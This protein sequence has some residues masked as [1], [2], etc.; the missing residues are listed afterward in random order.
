MHHFS[1][2]HRAYLKDSKLL[3]HLVDSSA[4]GAVA[5]CC[6][7]VFLCRTEREQLFLTVTRPSSSSPDNL[8]AHTKD[9]DDTGGERGTSIQP[10]LVFLKRCLLAAVAAAILDVDHFIAAGSFSISGA[11]HLKVISCHV[12]SIIRWMRRH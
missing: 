5:F 9:D 3:R 12:A 10:W 11:T 8:E 6:W 1:H 4:H 2:S 7:G